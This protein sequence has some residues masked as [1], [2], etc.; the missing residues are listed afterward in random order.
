M[1]AFEY[2][3]VVVETA[4]TRALR[5]QDS[6]TIIFAK[7]A[8]GCAFTLPAALSPG[9][10]VAIFSPGADSTIQAAPGVKIN[11]VVAAKATVKKGFVGSS[12]LALELDNAVLS[13]E[14][15]L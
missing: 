9:F 3:S 10:N 11:G 14:F 12:L 2:A 15:T 4:A 1:S 5:V 6:G 7:S 13:G 8:T